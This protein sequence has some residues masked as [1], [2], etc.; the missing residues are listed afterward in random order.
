M[1][2]RELIEIP[3]DDRDAELLPP[4]HEYFKS[5]WSDTSQEPRA[6]FNTFI[7]NTPIV[8]GVVFR[9][10]DA[11]EPPGLWCELSSADAE[12]AMLYLHGGAYTMGNADA[13][14]GFVSQIA[15][16]AQCSAFIPD[17]PLAPEA[18]IP[19]ALDM[20]RAAV[21]SLL[22]IYPGVFCPT[23]RNRRLSKSRALLSMVT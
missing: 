22:A 5:F 14:R 1:E 4:L 16:R 7:A 23:P 20:A 10:A 19:V 13:Y 12:R 3:L 2:D 8:D 6:K 11:S 18:S 21:D 15:S 9:S 17:Y